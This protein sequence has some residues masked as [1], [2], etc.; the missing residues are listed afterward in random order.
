MREFRQSS[1]LA[2][3][4]TVIDF[5]GGALENVFPDTYILVGQCCLGLGPV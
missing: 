3:F 2:F 5:F 1:R 4:P